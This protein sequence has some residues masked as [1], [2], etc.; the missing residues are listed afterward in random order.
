MTLAKLMT[1]LGSLV[2]ITGIHKLYCSIK[3]ES[4]RYVASPDEEPFEGA[5]V[6]N[7][8]SKSGIRFIIYGFLIQLIRLVV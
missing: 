4:E 7:K 5:V 3:P 6:D 1:V 2:I 8:L